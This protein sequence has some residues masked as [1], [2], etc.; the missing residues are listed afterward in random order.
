MGRNNSRRPA[1]HSRNRKGSSQQRAALSQPC[2]QDLP[3][4]AYTPRV[5][6]SPRDV[7]CRGSP[8]A[9]VR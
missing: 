7:P 5:L 6:A 8:G 2:P 9:D 1:P 4:V 3:E